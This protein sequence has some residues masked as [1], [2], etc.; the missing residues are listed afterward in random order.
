MTPKAAMIFAA[1]RGTR[2][3]ALTFDRPKP[4]IT[5]AGRALLDHALDLTRPVAPARVVVNAHHHGAMIRNHLAGRGVLISDETDLLRETGGGLRHALP[6]LGP[7]PV[8]T[9]NAD[10]VWRGANP[11]HALAATWDPARMEALLLML[12][13]DAAIGHSGAGDF[14]IGPDGR[15]SRGPGLVYSGAQII[16]PD[17]LSM[18]P[19]EVFSLNRLWDDMA[20]RGT[21]FGLRH[22]GEWCDVGRPES[23]ALAEAMLAKPADGGAHVH[24]D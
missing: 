11:L 16:L 4:L 22:D 15:L 21:L 1:G 14:V 2:M 20:A 13:R 12:P 3:G 5:V 23:I 9:L 8:F 18:I 24:S 6:L 19:D 7:G 17:R 10:A